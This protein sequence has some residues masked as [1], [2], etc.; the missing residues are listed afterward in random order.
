MRVVVKVQGGK[1]RKEE[2]HGFESTFFGFRNALSGSD[3]S[4]CEK[5]NDSQQGI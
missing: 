4:D 3:I 5:G 2:T 1:G